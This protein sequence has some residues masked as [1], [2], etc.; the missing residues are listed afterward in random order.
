[1]RVIFGLVLIVGIAFAGTAVYM[2]KNYIGAYQNALAAERAQ[3]WS[4]SPFL[5]QI[6]PRIV[7]L[8]S[9]LLGACPIRPAPKQV[10]RCPQPTATTPEKSLIF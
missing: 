8:F 1:M 6:K 10:C 7:F 9:P 5:V 4:R 3:R 2:A